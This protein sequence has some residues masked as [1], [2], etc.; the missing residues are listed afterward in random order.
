MKKFTL[1][2]VFLIVSVLSSFAEDR[3]LKDAIQVASSFIN[4]STNMKRVTGKVQNNGVTLACAFYK[5]IMSADA[6]A[7]GADLYLFNINNDGGFILVSGDKNT[8]PI[9]GYSDKG[10]FYFQ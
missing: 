7:E 10:N 6:N 5:G 3:D 2:A 9:L 4:A 8:E 1:L